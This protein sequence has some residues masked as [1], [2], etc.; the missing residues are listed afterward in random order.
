MDRSR[1]V[2]MLSQADRL[3]ARA[4]TAVIGQIADFDKERVAWR[5]TAIA[6]RTLR[7]F[8]DSLIALRGRRE[9][10]VRTIQQIDCGLI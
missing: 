10:I 3:I 1:E 6:E 9:L 7:A 2:A 4:E 8:T 5:D